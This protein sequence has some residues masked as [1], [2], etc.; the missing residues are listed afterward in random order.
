M[1][2]SAP[3]ALDTLNELAAALGDDASFATTTATN[4][5]LKLA[6]ASN[7][8]DLANAGTARTN[9]GL[10]T[11]AV[12]STAAIA[13]SGTGLATADQI[14]TFVTGLVYITTDTNTTYSA[15]TGLTLSGTTFNVGTLNLDTTGSAAT[16]TT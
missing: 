6:K 13:D 11:G 2:D 4:I 7:L 14:H 1:V 15:G 9:L 12:L 16:L 10:G 8:S 5:V 3:G